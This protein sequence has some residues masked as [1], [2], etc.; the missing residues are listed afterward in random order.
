MTMPKA[1]KLLLIFLASSSRLTTRAS[2]SNLFGTAR[3]TRYKLP[4]LA[5]PVSVFALLDGDEEVRVRS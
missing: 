5:L 1:D 4:V 2:L 3:S